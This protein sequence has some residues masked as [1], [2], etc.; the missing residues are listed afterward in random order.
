MQIIE[1]WYMCL[2][3]KMKKLYINKNGEKIWGKK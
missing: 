1:F 2:S 3:A